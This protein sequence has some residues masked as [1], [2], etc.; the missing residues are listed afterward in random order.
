MIEDEEFFAW[1]DGELDDE[2][3]ARVAAEVAASPELSARADEHRGLG[4]GL[5]AAFDPVMAEASVPPQFEAA[6]VIGLGAR[7]ARGRSRGWFGVPQW[8]AMAATLA[9]GLIV[10]NMVGGSSSGPVQNRDGRLIA[11][12]SLDQALDNQLASAGVSNGV[13]VGLTYRDR[14]G[15]ICRSFS[16]GAASGLACREAEDWRIRG[17]FQGAE[18]QA[19]D[20]RMA[21]G[22]DPRLATLIDETIAG[23]PFDAATEKAAMEKGWR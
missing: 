1:L 23:E 9:L 22:E 10:G 2:A 19:G 5:R 4:A 13:R 3:S 21:A 12:T 8:A 16:D 18:G 14:Q 6:P 11:A 20:Y 7:A 17:L 15:S